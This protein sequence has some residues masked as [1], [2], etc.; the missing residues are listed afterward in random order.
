MGYLFLTISLFSGA[1]KG[2]LGK[3]LSTHTQNTV[4]MISVNLLRMVFCCMIGFAMIAAE[5]F[6]GGIVLDAPAVITGILSGLAQSI[7]VL[8]WLMSVCNGT[9]MLTNI[10]LMLGTVVTI[11]LS[12]I[13]LQESVSLKQVLGIIILIGAVFVMFS[14]NSQV[15]SK[16]TLSAVLILAAC[17]V[18]NGL[19]GYFQKLFVH[20]SNSSVS[21]LSLISY[22]V[23]AFVFVLSL[24]I[25]KS[26]EK[27]INI[28]ALF[29]A[30]FVTILL[31][32]ICL[33]LNTYYITK[34]A[35]YLSS[36]Q[37]YPVYQGG[38]LVLNILISGLLLRE[39]VTIK[40]IIGVIMAFLAV[41]LV[42]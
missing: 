33:F 21:M 20:Y 6:T 23:S 18:S 29:K 25:G 10:S 42:K 30:N 3:K 7:F 5:C 24:C 39:K 27:Q 37:L 31:M 36:T 4:E 9:F 32:S 34:A 35:K 17:G 38:A 28:R 26:K 12:C 41:L 40:C 15:K 13:T 22:T 14:Y 19:S 16:M 2:Y 11:A 1:T 8:A